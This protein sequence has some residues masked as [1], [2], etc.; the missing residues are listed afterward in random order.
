[1]GELMRMPM[2]YVNTLY[3][4]AEQEVRSKE[5]QEQHAA[6]VLEDELEDEFGE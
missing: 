3:W 4:L 5:G 6:E 2:S 1:M